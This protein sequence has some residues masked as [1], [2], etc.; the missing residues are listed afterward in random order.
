MWEINSLSQYLCFLYSIIMG[1]A[2]GL[3]YELFCIDRVLF[4]RSAF[5]IFVQDVL[6]WIISAF[7]FFS[8]SVIF[9]NGQIRGYLLFGTFLGLVAFRLS[10]SRLFR[11]IVKPLRKL[12]KFLKVK[13]QDL[14]KKMLFY[15]EK[16]LNNVKKLIKKIFFSKNNK[17][18]EKNS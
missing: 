5:F 7:V 4:K 16:C 13:Y 1:G 8:F 6:F 3:I 14:L 15:L 17:I 2:I 10:F 12:I 18:L 11:L 9:S